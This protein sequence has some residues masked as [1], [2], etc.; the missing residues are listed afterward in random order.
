MN[1]WE[2]NWWDDRTVEQNE[3]NFCPVLNDFCY[4]GNDAC[5]DCVTL[6]AFKEYYDRRPK[7]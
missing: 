3:T 6:K 2:Y 5:K 1:A 4:E 7:E